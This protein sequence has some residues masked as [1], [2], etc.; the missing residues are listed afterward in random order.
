LISSGTS[1]EPSYFGDADEEGD[2]AFFFTEDQLVGQDK[3]EL[4]DVYD[5]RVGGGIAAQNPPVVPACEGEACMGAVPTTSP[6]Q[7]PGSAAFNGPGNA[8]PNH[9]AKKHRK[10][11]KKAKSKKKARGHAEKKGARR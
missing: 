5:A 11:K 6:G 3:D 9:Q 2:N 8:K 10:H 1:P 7:S 4:I